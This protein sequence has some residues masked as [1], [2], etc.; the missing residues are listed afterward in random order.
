M[1]REGN[2]TWGGKYTIQYTDNALSN[3]TPETYI[4][5]LTNVTPVN[6]IKLVSFGHSYEHLF[7]STEWLDAPKCFQI[8]ASEA[9]SG[10]ADLFSSPLIGSVRCL[11]LPGPL[12]SE[13]QR[14]TV[15]KGGPREPSQ[16]YF[17]MEKT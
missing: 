9:S 4:I 16:G 1:E 12:S 14:C 15:V 17:K 10:K 13:G 8:M 7:S 11:N 2:L 3:C 5:L 6:S